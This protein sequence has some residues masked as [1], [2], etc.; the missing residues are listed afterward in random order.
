MV[1][2]TRSLSAFPP[3]Q[4]LPSNIRELLHKL[5][6]ADHFNDYGVIK[7]PP[8]K[9]ILYRSELLASMDDKSISQSELTIICSAAYKEMSEEQRSELE[10]RAEARAAEHRKM[11]P[12][13]RYRPTSAEDKRKWSSMDP[14]KK[15]AFW[16]AA[17]VRVV[18]KITNPDGKWDGPVSFKQWTREGE[19]SETRLDG[20]NLEESSPAIRLAN[21]IKKPA[22]RGCGTG[23]PGQ[24]GS[25]SLRPHKFHPYQHARN[26]SSKSRTS[27][28]TPVHRRNAGLTPPPEWLKPFLM[29][30]ES[31]GDGGKRR[32]FQEQDRTIWVEEEVDDS[33]P[34][35]VFDKFSQGGPHETSKD[36]IIRDYAN[37]PMPWAF[38]QNNDRYI[39][40][41]RS[42]SEYREYIKEYNLARESRRAFVWVDKSA[43]TSEVSPSSDANQVTGLPFAPTPG[44]SQGVSL[45]SQ[46][47]VVTPGQPEAPAQEPSPVPVASNHASINGQFESITAQLSYPVVAN[48]QTVTEAPQFLAQGQVH[49]N[50]QTYGADWGLLGVTDSYQPPAPMDLMNIPLQSSGQPTQETQDTYQHAG[51]VEEESFP[52][53]FGEWVD[54][55]AME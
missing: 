12:G 26:H 17:A 2:D 43:P 10:R 50:D 19:G 7:R 34:K 54:F 3:F 16:F 46:F 53:I 18:E 28:Q 13:Y 30:L 27:A 15:K 49:M 21:T 38:D 32:R 6:E 45:A 36:L 33:V 51:M 42:I 5:V 20:C 44:L 29:H 55:L 47:P 23:S 41:I 48:D 11:F 14:A 37:P 39:P 9:W 40:T 4:A 35:H 24:S 1:F 52:T 8:N 31:P 25:T 22:T